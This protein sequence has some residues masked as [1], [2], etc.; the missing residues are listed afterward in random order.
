MGY[1]TTSGPER[2]PLKGRAWRRAKI[3][4]IDENS[5]RPWPVGV[6]LPAGR[7]RDGVR[8]WTLVLDDVALPGCWVVVDRRFRPVK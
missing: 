4:V 5:A 7:R 1:L 6:A 3:G 8:L 2:G